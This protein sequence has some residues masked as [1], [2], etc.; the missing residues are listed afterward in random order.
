MNKVV[1]AYDDTPGRYTELAAALAHQGIMFACV[2]HPTALNQVLDNNDCLA[3]MLDFDVRP[4]DGWSNYNGLS[5]CYEC[6]I[7]RQ[8]PVCITSYNDPGSAT[9]MHVLEEAGVEVKRIMHDV[10]C[11]QHWFSFILAER[12]PS[13]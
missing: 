3:V 11:L 1:V 5:T 7:H 12:K 6:L 10:G 2:E 4:V 8:V 13:V 9:M